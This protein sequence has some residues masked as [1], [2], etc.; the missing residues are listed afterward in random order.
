MALKRPSFDDGE[1]GSRI[2]AEDIKR[3]KSTVVRDVTGLLSLTEMASR[4]EPLF[5]RTIREEL[6]KYTATILE[7]SSRHPFHQ[8][9]SS[10]G[11]DFLLYFVNKLPSTIFTGRRIEA[12]NGEP[13]QI[14]LMDAR[15]KTPVTFGPLSSMKIELLVLDA[16]FGSDDREN[17][18]ENEFNSSIIRERDGRRPLITGERFIALKNGVAQVT[19]LIFTDNSSW[20]RSRKF[21][22]GAKQGQKISGEVKIREGRSEAFMVKDHRGVSYQKHHPPHLDDEVW[23]LK[24]IARDGSYHTRLASNGIHTVKDF[25]QLHATDPSKLR[26][27]LG[28]GVSSRTWHVIIE[29]ASSCVPEDGQFYAY[30]EP[31]IGL[32]FNSVYKVVGAAFDGQ[33]YEPLD[34]LTPPQK[35]LVEKSKRQAYKNVDNFTP[36]NSHAIFGPSTPLI[37]P[38]VE[39]FEIPTVGQDKVQMQLDFNT[40]PSTKKYSFEIGSGSQFQIPLHSSP[41]QMFPPMLKNSFKLGD[42][43]SLPYPADNSFSPNDLQ[44][45][46]LI[47]G[48]MTDEDICRVQAFTSVGFSSTWGQGSTSAFLPTHGTDDETDFF[49][50]FRSQSV[51]MSRIRKPKTRWCQLRAVMRWGSVRRNVAHRRMLNYLCV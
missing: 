1:D 15:T 2:Q 50:T 36:I 4:M 43:F 49:S 26:S 31:D 40:Q 9:E 38:Q 32:L 30:F 45:P 34:K 16:D 51:D 44:W 12:D 6:E 8:S 27:M 7:P 29:H 20:Q 33:N 47:S 46:F 17:W 37:S 41:M 28:N 5:R 22:L 48:Q 21:R 11:A 35:A 24:K 14:L 13:I 19:D 18:T 42:V 25:L 10:G 3:F 23:R 39:A